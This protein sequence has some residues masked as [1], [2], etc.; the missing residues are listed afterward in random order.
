MGLEE[1]LTLKAWVEG[2]IKMADL[3]TLNYQNRMFFIWVSFYS[4]L[5]SQSWNLCFQITNLGAICTPADYNTRPLDTIYSNFIDALPMIRV[6][7]KSVVNFEVQAWIFYIVLLGCRIWLKGMD[8]VWFVF[9]LFARWSTVLKI[10]RGL[11]IICIKKHICL[12]WFCFLTA[13]LVCFG[14]IN[15]LSATWRRWRWRK[16]RLY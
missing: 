2:L 9:L 6:L 7:V 16:W 15:G 5:G 4:H 1:N 11:P 10:T 12:S 14:S 13:R 8:V 3:V